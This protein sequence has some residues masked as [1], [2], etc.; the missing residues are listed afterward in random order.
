MLVTDT[1]PEYLEK[2][3]DAEAKEFAEAVKTL[4]TEKESLEEQWNILREGGIYL[5]NEVSFECDGVRL[6]KIVPKPAIDYK[7]ALEALCPNADLTP[8]LKFTK[9]QWR[10]NVG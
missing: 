9:P 6:I 10:L 2:R 3:D 1:P 4:K 8:F 7:S 5:A